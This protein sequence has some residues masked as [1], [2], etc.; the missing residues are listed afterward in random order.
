MDEEKDKEQEQTQEPNETKTEDVSLSDIMS[1]MKELR[2]D[3]TASRD[4]ITSLLS[5]KDE[6]TDKDEEVSDEET[7]EVVEE[8]NDSK[9]VDDSTESKDDDIEAVTKLFDE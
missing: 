6:K 3:F 2:A 7:T 5:N 9:K 4:E 8:D 1:F